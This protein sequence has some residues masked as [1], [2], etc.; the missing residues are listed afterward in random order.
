MDGEE[1]EWAKKR[2]KRRSGE[3]LDGEERKWTEKRENGRRRE[4]GTN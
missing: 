1:E 3:K 4:R 2:E